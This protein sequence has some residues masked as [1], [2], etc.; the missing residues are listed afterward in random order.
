MKKLLLGGCLLLASVSTVVAQEKSLREFRQKYKGCAETT[1]IKL[2]G[3]SLRLAGWVMSF[4]KEDEDVKNVRTLLKD[5]RK[6]KVHTI[7]NLHGAS[8][9]SDDVATLKRR[10]QDRDHFETLMEV[11][12]KGSLVH[13]MNKGKDD[14][15]GHVVMLI[16]DTNEFTMVNLETNLKIAD[17]NRLIN[18]FASN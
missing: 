2:G 15:L 12:D 4:D 7:E 16:Q 11:R 8:I 3:M 18:Q 6:V 14:E 9:S 13:I 1:S 10:L 5:L 17:I